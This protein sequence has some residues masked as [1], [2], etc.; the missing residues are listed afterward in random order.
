MIKRRDRT[1]IRIAKMWE[2]CVILELND[3]LKKIPLQQRPIAFAVI[4]ERC[5]YH[6]FKKIFWYIETP[7]FEQR[8]QGLEEKEIEQILLAEF[9]NNEKYIKIVIGQV[10]KYLPRWQA[11]ENAIF[12]RLEGKETAY[13]QQNIYNKS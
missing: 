11:G 6:A 10:S 2:N 9:L 5:V 3:E 4:H 7:E 13:R 1:A 12:E 8:M